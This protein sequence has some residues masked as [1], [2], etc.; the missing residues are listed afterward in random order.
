[1]KKSINELNAD[2]FHPQRDKKS[3]DPKNARKKGMDFLAIREYGHEE[4][5]LKLQTK[6]YSRQP[7]IETVD[8][9]QQDGLQDDSRFAES[10]SRSRYKQGKGPARITHELEAKKLAI[11]VIDA[12][13]ATLEV[14]WFDLA[15]E[16]RVRKFGA[17]SPLEYKEKSKQMRFLQSRGFSM[18]QISAAFKN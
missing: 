12:A 15:R 10:Y 16:V 2:L 6:G 14:D 17:E 13:L 5:I 8:K 9:L 7:S 3:V 4:L 18:E 1:M 11:K